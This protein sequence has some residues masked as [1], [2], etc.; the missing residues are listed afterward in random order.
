MKGWASKIP[1]RGAAHYLV[2]D[3]TPFCANLAYADGRKALAPFECEW[4]ELRI[5]D[6][7]CTNC[8]RAYPRACLC[9]RCNVR[10]ACAQGC[11][12]CVDH[13]FEIADPRAQAAKRGGRCAICKA[14]CS[15]GSYCCGCD[16]FVCWT[17]GEPK[18]LKFN[19]LHKPTDHRGVR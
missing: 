18:G 6:H 17:H 14:S 7:L 12:A 10:P 13:H 11:E 5:T 19:E 16:S 9:G 1:A 15:A 8:V 2:E 3:G 4:T